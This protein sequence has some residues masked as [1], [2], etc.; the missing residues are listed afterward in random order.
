MKY[1]FKNFVWSFLSEEVLEVATTLPVE[2]TSRFPSLAGDEIFMCALHDGEQEP[3]LV[4]M[5]LVGADTITVERAQEGTLARIWPK[6]T[7][8]F[9]SVTAAMFDLVGQ[10]ATLA[11]LVEFLP[12]GDLE[13][14]NVQDAIEELMRDLDV[15][16]LDLATL[17]TDVALIEAELAGLGGVYAPLV[18]THTSSEVTD[19]SEAVDD[20]VAALLQEGTNV[21]LVYDDA[22]GT[23]TI[24][25]SGGSGVSD[26]NKG[27]ITVSAGG[28]VWDINSWAVSVAEVSGLTTALAGKSDVGH[29][30][31][32]SYAPLVHAHAIS[33]VTGLTAALDAKADD[34]EITTINTSL[35]GK[36]PLDAM[37]TALAALVTV[38][39]RG[40]YFTGADAPALYGMTAYA[41]TLMDDA[42]AGTAQTTLG[43]STFIK[44]LLDD[45]DAAAA[46]ATLGAAGL[47]VSNTFTAQQTISG[48][49][50]NLAILGTASAS[51]VLADSGAAA[52]QQRV[53]LWEDGGL[54]RFIHTS[55]DGSSFLTP[56]ILRLGL[57][58]RSII[59]G[60]ATGGPKGDGTVNASNYYK[61]GTALTQ[62]G[63]L[64]AI[65]TYT[66][67]ATWTK[68]AG[69]DFIV[70]EVQGA[71]GGSGGSLGVAAQ[72]AAGRSGAC[73]AFAR[74]TIAAAS[75][76][77][78]ETVTVG[79]R[80]TAGAA[81]PTSG[82]NGGTSSFGSHVSCTGGEG[83]VIVAAGTAVTWNDASAGGIATGGD[84][85]CDGAAG[86]M[87]CRLSASQGATLSAGASY[88]GGG[89]E[90]TRN[91]SDAG[92]ASTVPGGGAGGS[93]QIGVGS[94]AGALGGPGLV[95]IYEYSL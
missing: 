64:T 81:T 73:G 9:N 84:I 43:I 85:N 11:S 61:N 35:A 5:V 33:D 18:H 27:D 88:Y 22:L 1:V 71:G 67:G 52:G 32:A 2:D 60:G 29:N 20:R 3:E 15:V 72:V 8:V 55:D 17:A 95:T 44:G 79:A 92:T 66:A 75:L 57:L 40:L 24:H 56:D 58:D 89:A 39:D 74:K 77:A 62:A 70:V 45:A 82:G 37:L 87:Q 54:L 30:H 80:G 63:N 7:K 36:Q 13:S 53:I 76:G 47:T 6:G 34:S 42:D 78:T 28:T 68:P 41:R 14:T 69:L 94:V 59:V 48:A 91:G 4:R 51:L 90:G 31:D 16:E 10:P 65:R 26:G 21:S 49:N 50:P 86:G 23:L 83:G 25:S 46:R 93:Q 19:F 12:A 38:G